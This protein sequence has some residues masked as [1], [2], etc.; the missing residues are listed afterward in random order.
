MQ[1]KIKIEILGN[2]YDITT[3]EDPRYVHALADEINA[4]LGTILKSNKISAVQALV[5]FSLQCLDSEKKA[6]Q[7]ADNLREQITSYL[8]DI[9]SAYTE[10]ENVT[11]ELDK[12]KKEKENNY[13]H[14]NNA[15]NA[16][17]RK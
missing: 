15:N 10:L 6:V 8:D 2:Q 3:S 9:N 1:N 5:L 7:T 12:L 17:N 14:A 11:N 13:A 4:A 16:K